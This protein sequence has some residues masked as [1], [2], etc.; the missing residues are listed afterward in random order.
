MDCER[1]MRTTMPLR[2]MAQVAAAALAVLAGPAEVAVAADHSWSGAGAAPSG[3]WSNAANWSGGIAPVDGEAIGALTFPALTHCPATAA[4]GR[5]TN[6]ITGL[7]VN[8]LAINDTQTASAD[9]VYHI[10]GNGITLTSGLTAS[11]GG[12]TSI[13]SG[14]SSFALPIALGAPQRWTVRGSPTPSDPRRFRAPEGVAITSPVTGA[15]YPLVID[16]SNGASL[17]LSSD[18]EVG[19]VFV[20]GAN[21]GRSGLAAVKNGTL[22]LVVQLDRTP[23]RLNATDGNAVTIAHAQLQADGEFGPMTLTGGQLSVGAGPLVPA[24]AATA[25]AVTLDGHSGAAFFIPGRGSAAGTD[26]SQIR[27]A[28]PVA[29]SGAHLAVTV[30]RPGARCPAPPM[31]TVYTLVA[32]TATVTGTF[33]VPEGNVLTLTDASPACPVDVPF[34]L[35]I[36]YHESGSPQT[37]TATVVPAPPPGVQPGAAGVARVSGTVLVRQRGR[38]TFTPLTRTTVILS[39]SELDTTHGRVRLFVATNAHGGTTAAELYG[40]RFTFRQPRSAH[41]RTTFA[42]S[43]PLTGC[44]RAAT[45]TSATVA[46]RHHHRP[47][48][49]YVWV[50]EQ[51]GSFDTR[52][53]YVSTS[54]QGTTWLTADT[55][56]T[57]LV[58]VTQGTVTVHDLLHHRAV[59]LRAGQ[60]YTVRRGR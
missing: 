2:R 30:G 48:A 36:D 60:R 46:R 20:K 24:G 28:G 47:R 38:T 12:A 21:A 14:L 32:S 54:V 29:L 7:T 5:S 53:Q 55:C 51:G 45:A 50:T 58:K 18:D 17:V 52:A 19:P 3:S 35:R 39:G 22:A 59:K 42:L 15:A 44:P 8:T 1:E 34:A 31:G 41:P 40:G 27:S 6:D 26:Y 49:R 25:A 11:P 23:A 43:Q 13:G 57:S 37:V 56:A 33:D 10:D 4:C 16:I 9:G